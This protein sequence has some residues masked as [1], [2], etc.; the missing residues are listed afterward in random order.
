MSYDDI[1][2]MCHFIMMSSWS[3]YTKNHPIIWWHHLN[4][5]ECNIF[6]SMTQS[7]VII[8][9]FV[10]LSQVAPRSIPILLSQNKRSS[11]EDDS[12]LCDCKY[13]DV[14]IVIEDRAL[15]YAPFKR[16]Y[17][18]MSYINNNVSSDIMMKYGWSLLM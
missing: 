4:H 13:K 3:S 5:N 18:Y 14:A 1:T 7:D 8:R 12:L 15:M 16:I 11:T 6:N 17:K 2:I 9:Q 10:H